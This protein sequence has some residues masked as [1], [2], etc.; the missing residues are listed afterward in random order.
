MDT[1]SIYSN[2]N[3]ISTR[4]STLEQE[5]H[6]TKRE[7]AATK[8]ELAATKQELA[9]TSKKLVDIEKKVN[10]CMTHIMYESSL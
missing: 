7:L 2:V 9:A 4:L 10:R 5:H 8:Q 6:A 1:Y 3:A